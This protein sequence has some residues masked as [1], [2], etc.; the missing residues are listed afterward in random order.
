MTVYCGTAAGAG[1]A[2]GFAAPHRLHCRFLAKLASEQV[3]HSQSPAF[4]STQG[5]RSGGGPPPGG[6]GFYSTVYYSIA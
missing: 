4:G 3:A 1:G 2:Q 6:T 5:F